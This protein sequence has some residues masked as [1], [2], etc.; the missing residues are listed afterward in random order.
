MSIYLLAK[1]A[2][3]KRRETQRNSLAPFYLNM[4]HTGRVI[5]KC[6]TNRP[7]PAPQKCYGQYMRK[8]KLEFVE[9][10]NDVSHKK[11][12]QFHASQH[13]A[14]I[15]SHAIKNVECCS[16]STPDDT[17]CY[18]KCDNSNKKKLTITKDVGMNKPGSWVT[19]R[20]KANRV[21]VC[22]QEDGAYKKY[23][24]KTYGNNPGGCR[25]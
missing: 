13:T 24:S 17:N 22:E 9:A 10:R 16:S 15:T 21:C 18:N 6:N 7:T 5:S 23:E 14:N 4:T 19:A 1:K 3:R 20:V 8:K 11:M 25:D 12:P 2:Q